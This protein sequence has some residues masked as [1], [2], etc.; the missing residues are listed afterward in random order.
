MPL[1]GPPNV[2]KLKEKRDVPKLIKAL[3]YKEATVRESAA[4]A[5]GEIGDSRAVE[6][7]SSALNDEDLVVAMAARDALIKIGAP[8]VEPLLGVLKEG[9]KEARKRAAAA[10]GKIGAPAVESLLA[11]LKSD[12]N[13]VRK[14]AVEALGKMGIP[15][16]VEPL[17]AALKDEDKAVRKSAVVALGEIGDAQAVEPLCSALQDEDKAV[18]KSA[19]EALGELGDARAVEPLCSALQDEDRDVRFGAATALGKLGDAR[20]MEPLLVALKDDDKAVR[21]RAADALGKIGEPAVEPLLVALKDDDMGVQ[22]QAQYALGKIGEPAMESLLAA[23]K[24]DSFV[25]RSRAADALVKIGTPALRPLLIAVH[26]DDQVRRM[27]ERSLMKISDGYEAGVC[28]RQGLHIKGE[29]PRSLREE[30]A[31]AMFYHQPPSRRACPKCRAVA[32]LVAQHGDIDS[33]GRL[34]LWC[35]M[36]HHKAEV[37]M[38]RTEFDTLAQDLRRAGFKPAIVDEFEVI[39]LQYPDATASHVD[40]IRPLIRAVSDDPALGDTGLR[41]LEA[42]LIA[43]MTVIIADATG[44]MPDLQHLLGSQESEG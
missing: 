17:L 15:A 16:V 26:D 23:L 41:M 30:V 27:A 2:E 12:D 10:L 40:E 28:A 21:K 37:N 32:L 22:Q 6:P 20:A 11:A 24:D 3:G 25:V 31:R 1:F 43:V 8:A 39:H 34:K 42:R 14:T 33:R 13:V 18:R 4:Q 19:V 9:D 44:A 35:V 38:T 29:R 7:L 36:C 5:L